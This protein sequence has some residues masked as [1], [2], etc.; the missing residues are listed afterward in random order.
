MKPKAGTGWCEAE[1]LV[2]K[3]GD[4]K[5]EKKRQNLKAGEKG[6]LMNEFQCGLNVTFSFEKGFVPDYIQYKDEFGIGKKFLGQ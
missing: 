1:V 3:K 2:G 4:E 5:I 6:K